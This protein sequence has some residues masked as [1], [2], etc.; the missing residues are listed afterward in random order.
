MLELNPRARPQDALEKMIISLRREELKREGHA[1]LDILT[2]TYPE[3]KIR[4]S[5]SARMGMKWRGKDTGFHY[6]REN[7]IQQMERANEHLKELLHQKRLYPN[8][9]HAEKNITLSQ[10][11]Y[12]KAMLELKRLKRPWWE[13]LLDY[14]QK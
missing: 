2:K 13:K 1:L 12:K 6:G 9:A 7:T 11:K 4:K 10:E 3:D 14:L 8:E 5:L